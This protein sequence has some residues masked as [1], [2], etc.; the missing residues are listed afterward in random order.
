MDLVYK[1]EV[2]HRRE[3][4]DKRIGNLCHGRYLPVE[5]PTIDR[6]TKRIRVGLSEKHLHVNVLVFEYDHDIVE[7]EVLCC[8]DKLREAWNGK[9][10][11]LEELDS[12]VFEARG[13]DPTN[14]A[15]K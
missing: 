1:R 5:V 2:L 7:P 6:Y 9:R 11:L 15:S 14:H 13:R 10:E 8:V 12:Q 4:L 3:H